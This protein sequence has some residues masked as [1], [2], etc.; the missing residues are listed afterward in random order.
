MGKCIFFVLA[1]VFTLPACRAQFVSVEDSLEVLLP[2]LHNRALVDALSA[3]A[4]ENIHSDL[5]K[6]DRYADAADSLAIKIHYREG[7]A[8]A[9]I[10]KGYGFYWRGHLAQAREVFQREY[11]RSVALRFTRGIYMGLEGV[12]I[13]SLRLGETKKAYACVETQSAF[14]KTL[15]D[16]VERN[17][18]ITEANDMRIVYHIAMHEYN[19]A[20]QVIRDNLAFAL[21][22]HGSPRTMGMIMKA[23]GDL[24]ARENHTRESIAYLEQAREYFR[25][26]RDR[27]NYISCR[28]I[29]AAMYA[30]AGETEKAM[31]IFEDLLVRAK[32]RGY[33]VGIATIYRELAALYVTQGKFSK[34][35]ALQLEALG[36]FT[37]LNRVNDMMIAREALGKTYVKLGNFPQAITHFRQALSLSEQNV[38]V[39]ETRRVLSDLYIL[40]SQASLRMNERD[41]AEHYAHKAMDLYTTTAPEEMALAVPALNNLAR[42]FLWFHQSDLAGATLAQITRHLDS[43]QSKRDQVIYYN[44]MGELNRQRKSYTQSVAAF[45]KA[46]ILSKAAH[47]SEE[48][49]LAMRGL[50]DVHGETQ[51]P[52]E[53]LA[54]LENYYALKD[55]VYSMATSNEITDIIVKY[56][57]AEK[58]R[59]ITMLKSA[60]VVQEANLRTQGITLILI[61]VVLA[62]MA[63]L[64][65]ILIHAN[66]VNKKNNRT[67]SDKNQEIEL[68]NEEI[69]SKTEE[70]ASQHEKLKRSLNDLKYTQTMLIH[71]EKMASLGQLTAGVAH[72]IN[73]PVNF[74]SNGVEGLT[75]Q[76]EILIALLKQYDGVATAL[77]EAEQQALVMLKKSLGFD[78]TL[79]DIQDLTKLINTGVERTT[80]IVK[81]LR[82]FSHE[83]QKAFSH[84]NLNEQLDATLVMT[85]SEMRGRIEVIKAYDPALPLIECNIGEINQVLMNIVL[86]G[87]QAIEGKG[88]L[89]IA[90]HWDARERNVRVEI[91]DTGQGIPP[92]LKGLIFDPFFTTKEVGKGTGL[93]LAITSS[94]VEKHRGHIRVESEEGHGACFIVTLPETQT[95][96]TDG[97]VPKTM[98][99][100]LPVTA[101]GDGKR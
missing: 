52:A 92:D 11:D 78:D 36:L 69:A 19:T 97:G 28:M 39:G 44:S 77:P 90:T 9:R 22:H 54:H 5:E 20:H 35:I 62:L 100:A 27:H 76:I 63:L 73:N 30:E 47:Y 70:I 3:I 94:I 99:S 79:D 32:Q 33:R 93:G 85:Q 66:R 10:I 26:V 98:N 50:H 25:I 53:A 51:H 43:I 86:N 60:Q 8:M 68:Q 72:E 58:D 23:M 7:E 42:V 41:D 17:F 13:T 88:V 56:Q 15:P 31:Y 6:L 14:V 74:I 57:T 83:G 49:L 87:I 29:Q 18:Y 75:R 46:L 89:T 96:Q 91:A 1:F 34:A 21:E 59:E 40:L 71:S 84:V 12:F 61:S 2:R 55:S 16:T 101:E 81:S 24:E 80:H 95:G 45:D 48:Q 67:L 65:V 64:A 4:E 82:I 38:P 37:D